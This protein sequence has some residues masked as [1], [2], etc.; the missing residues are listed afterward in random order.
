MAVDHRRLPARFIL[1]LL[2]IGL[3]LMVRPMDVQAAASP[4][5]ITAHLGYTDV[6]KTQQWMPL[7]IAITNNGPEVDGTLVV[8]SILGGKPGVAWP[9]S[10]ERPLVLAAGATKYF[11]FYV[12]DDSGMTVGVSVVRNGRILAQQNAAANRTAST[13]IGV[14]SDDSAALDDFAVVHPGSVSATVVHLGLADVGDS[15][16]ALRAF[17][18]LA[19][20]DFATD[21]LTASQKS[22][23][24]DF[25][26]TGGSLL[27]GTGASWRRTLAGLPNELVPIHLTGLTTLPSSQAFGGLD[28]VQAATGSLTAGSAWLAQ[29]DQP[30]LVDST[31]GAGSVTMATFDWKQEPISS[32]AGTKPLLRQVL[33][34][35]MFGP[36][37]QQGNGG[38]VG[39]FAGPF[40][41]PFGGQGGSIYQRSASLSPVLGNL[42]ALD[43]PSLVLT[44]VLVLAYVLLVGP[45][46]YFVLGA[47]HRR[48]LS[49]I[50]L[51]L[52]AVLVA[53]AGYGGGIWTKGQSV[54]TNQVSIIHVEPGSAVGYQETYTGV[55]TPTRGDYEVSLS[56][57]TLLVSPISSYNGFGGNGRADIRVMV[58]EGKVVLP[59]MTAFTLRGFATEGMI[60]APRLVGHLTVLNGQMTGSIQNQSAT[61]LTDAVIIAGDGFQKLGALAPGATVSV[62]FMP[63][64]TSFQN[65]PPAIFGIY[66]NYMFGPPPNQP[67]E[68]VRDGQAKTQILSLLQST[69]FKGMPST[70]VTPMVVAWTN[71]SFQDVTVNG[72]HPRAHTQTAVAMT[73]AVDE[74]GA[75][76]LPVGVV[77][78]RLVDYDGDAQQQGPPGTL[79]V[80]D[81]TV[82][83]QFMPH[84][85]AGVHL[86]GAT[87]SSSNPVFVK[88]GVGANGSPATVRGSA[89][90]W[91]SSTWVD[92]PYQENATTALPAEVIN[93]TT[94]E[95]RLRV[96]VSNGSFLPSGISLAGTVQ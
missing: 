56:G 30:L 5:T 51:P 93:P 10:Y 83:L 60:A 45:I 94:G 88:G 68:V 20:D 42:P 79:V 8:Q 1:A 55:L 26:Q 84:L 12:V 41:G 72:A 48:S 25:V 66:P 59:G 9:A 18:L 27:I 49:W 87:L 47:L 67:G 95:V 76:Q 91:S 32:W 19:I 39:A 73:L 81:G 63:K 77:G 43:L 96:T 78:G 21:S 14:L 92:I 24:A 69:N 36:Q 65:G 2:L 15:A 37:S 71:Q 46:N 58:D 16:L 29:G 74:V 13:L 64:A 17:D 38:G 23:I 11:R 35:T 70:A 80:Q 3:A 90:D 61:Y 7:S 57:R 82:T 53:G 85:A 62:G 22:A 4:L 34:R 31:V 28:G 54:Q 89:W 33:V 6:I 44:G 40:G 86:T 50:T 75:G 52:I